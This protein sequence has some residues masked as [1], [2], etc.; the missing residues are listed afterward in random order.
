MRTSLRTFLPALLC[1]SLAAPLASQAAEPIIDVH[2]HAFCDRAFP[3]GP[4]P[5]P[6]T[7]KPTTAKSADEHRQQTI[8]A[9]KRNNIVLGLVSSACN[10][11]SMAEWKDA[12]GLRFM[13]GANREGNRFVTPEFVREQRK[14]GK[15]HHLGELTAQYFGL[16]PTEK[17]IA[18]LFAVAEELDM[19]LFL[20]TGLGPP[21]TPYRGSPSF[22]TNFGNPQLVE[23]LLVKHPKARVVL[24]H[25]GYPYLAET[26]AILYIYPQVYADI[27]VLNWYLPREEFH[28]YLQELVRAGFGERLLFGSDQMIWPEA[29]DLAVEG[30]KSASFL[31]EKQ[32]RDI[33]YNNAARLLRLNQ[34]PKTP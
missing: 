17:E 15:L 33:F 30:V 3:R 28:A 34:A 24:M 8:E 7:G 27:A 18:D 20:H 21:G 10:L 14:A 32:K 19:P 22:R 11:D 5:N 29:I 25:A 1:F 13:L 16:S 9:L 2:L 12:D 26:K 4:V 23:S 6:V 31:S